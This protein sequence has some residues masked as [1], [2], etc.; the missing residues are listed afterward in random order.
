MNRE[1][2][3]RGKRMGNGEWIEGYAAK[4]GGAF[5]ICDNGLTYGGFEVFEVSPATVG[6]YTGLTD[7]NEQKIFEGDIVLVSSGIEDSQYKFE[8]RYGPCGGV[9]NVEHGVGYIGFFF[10]VITSNSCI[11]TW[12]RT[13]PIYFLEAGFYVEVIGNVH[14]NPELLE[15]QG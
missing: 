12:L 2:L 1:F 8:V 11:K 14:D 4:S 5:I 9:K 13:D 3:F 15:V 10:D 6:Q 7:N